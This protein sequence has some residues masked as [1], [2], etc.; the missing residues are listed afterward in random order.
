LGLAARVAERRVNP[1]SAIIISGILETQ[2][3]AQDAENAAE[4]R[5]EKA[6]TA[7]VYLAGINHAG[8]LKY[9]AR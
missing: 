8:D 4:M 5:A 1:R 2:N 3:P 7:G 9:T 6:L